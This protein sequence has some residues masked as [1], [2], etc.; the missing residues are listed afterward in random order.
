MDGLSKKLE[1]LAGLVREVVT[2]GKV[3]RVVTHHDAD[4][5]CAGAIVH[6]AIVRMGGSVHTRSIKQ[7]ESKN[8]GEVLGD[9]SDLFIFVDMGSGQLNL[10]SDHCNSTAIV[11]DHHQPKEAPGEII[12]V[13][14]HH[15]GIDG[16][17]EVSGAGMA[18]LFA[19][20][21]DEANVDLSALAIVGAVGDIQEEDGSFVGLNKL[22][23][24]DAVGANVIE[25]EKDL[26]L[27]GRQTRP[28]YKA[29]E[30]TTEPFI[31][32]LSGSESS[33]IQFLS[34]L[35][36]PLRKDG[37][38]TLLADLNG[39]ERQRLVTALIL[40]M[41][42][43]RVPTDVAEGIIGDVY[44]LLEEERKTPLRDAR[45]FATLLNGCGKHRHNGIGIAVCLGDRKEQYEKSLEMLRGHKSYI[46][47]CY[48]W[49][50]KN[51]ERIR[52]EGIL[53][54]FHAGSEIDSNVI[55]TVAF[56]VLAS[57]LLEPVK[58]I[59]AFSY[60]DEG[61]VKVSSRGKKDLVG[62]GLNLGRAMQY[63]SEKMGRGD[64]GG[65]DIAAGATIEKG[66][67]EEFLGYVME[68]VGRQFHAGTGEA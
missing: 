3:A 63:A 41:I 54:S 7:L 30:Y 51:I 67:E 66:K 56:M 11:L 31:P 37:G 45:E 42:E 65:H 24:E 68:E 64:G 20:Q 21:M 61:D 44:T 47:T 29:I 8:A 15:H 39:D 16:S 40:K 2:E 26:R 32:G 10:I 22:V 27:F 17:R 38:Y 48:G 58:P 55:G 6:K 43:H 50:L 34:E 5:I 52:D 4:G 35:D 12:H 33:C 25:M 1:E 23:L 9:K 62:Q 46:S 59:V 53:Y 57:G 14:P 28:L 36:I 18:Y 13:N 60:T 19:K 49:I